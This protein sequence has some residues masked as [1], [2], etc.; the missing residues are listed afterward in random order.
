MSKQ[1]LIPN[2]VNNIIPDVIPCPKHCNTPMKF[3]VYAN[4]YYIFQCEKC[5]GL[6]RFGSYRDIIKN[7][8]CN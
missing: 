2:N 4:D 3:M 1:N 8:T 7:I 5:K 6:C